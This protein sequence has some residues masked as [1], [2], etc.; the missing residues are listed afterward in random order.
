MDFIFNNINKKCSFFYEW[1]MNTLKTDTVRWKN[2]ATNRF[3]LQI[4]VI[5]QQSCYRVLFPTPKYCCEF[6]S[7]H[8]VDLQSVHG[9]SCCNSFVCLTATSNILNYWSNYKYICILLEEDWRFLYQ[10]RV[11]Y[12]CIPPPHK[13]EKIFLKI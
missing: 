7:S 11:L 1:V 4:T 2:L 13:I 8:G 3:G 9:A 6:L 12:T 5:L 10:Y